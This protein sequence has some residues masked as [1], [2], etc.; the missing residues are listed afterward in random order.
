MTMA[1]GPVTFLLG[2]TDND[3]EQHAFITK[4]S[5]PVVGIQNSGVPF[6]NGTSSSA[7]TQKPMMRSMYILVTTYYVY[8]DV[9]SFEDSMSHF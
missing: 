8:E 3:E 1:E 5:I 7:S 6:C 9:F 4:A 2:S